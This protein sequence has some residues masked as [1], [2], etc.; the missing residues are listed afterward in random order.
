MCLHFKEDLKRFPI[1]IVANQNTRTK[2][3][4]TCQISKKKMREADGAKG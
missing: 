1:A 4:V 3:K 2:S